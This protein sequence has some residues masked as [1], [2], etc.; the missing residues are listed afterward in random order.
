MAPLLHRA[1]ITSRQLC[2]RKCRYVSKMSVL[3]GSLAVC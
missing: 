3:Y 1:V 2:C